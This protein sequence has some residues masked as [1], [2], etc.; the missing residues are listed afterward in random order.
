[1]GSAQPDSR[2]QRCYKRFTFN[3]LSSLFFQDVPHCCCW[4][5]ASSPSTLTSIEVGNYSTEQ[6]PHIM[7]AKQK[8][9]LAVRSVWLQENKPFLLYVLKQID[10]P[11]SLAFLGKLIAPIIFPDLGCVNYFLPPKMV[12]AAAH[13][14][15]RL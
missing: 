6:L 9:S 15:E 2:R 11:Q 8:A 7:E 10:F 4:L 14:F 5:E 12:I 1:M 3:C 13:G